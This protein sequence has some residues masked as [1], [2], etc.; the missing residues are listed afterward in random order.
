MTKNEIEELS[1]LMEAPIVP[2]GSGGCEGVAVG[3][4]DCGGEE[5]DDT[6]GDS[7]PPRLG[8]NPLDGDRVGDPL[9]EWPDCPDRGACTPTVC[10]GAGDSPISL[11]VVW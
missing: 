1:A 8:D 5:A 2:V 6:E 3:V 4:G 7:P 10:D 11:L 9:G